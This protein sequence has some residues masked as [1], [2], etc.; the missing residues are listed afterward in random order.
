MEANSGWA[1]WYSYSGGMKV[2]NEWL[3]LSTMWVPEQPRQCGD[4]P[5]QQQNAPTILKKQTSL[6]IA[7][8][9]LQENS[10]ALVSDLAIFRAAVTSEKHNKASLHG[11]T[12]HK[13]LKQK[14]QKVGFNSTKVQ[15]GVPGQPRRASR[16]KP[17]LQKCSH[18][19]FIDMCAL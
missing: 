6:Q 8:V 11:L 1:W 12:F 17:D 15:C 14:W 16:R 2:T 18:N 4:H 5:K 3:L 19:V 9:A 10:W 7:R 13:G